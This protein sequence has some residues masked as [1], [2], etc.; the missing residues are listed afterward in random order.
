MAA[1]LP[2]G[3][4][5]ADQGEGVVKR[6]VFMTGLLRAVCAALFLAMAA[7][8]A[9]EESPAIRGVIS[10]QL[11]AFQRDDWEGAF[12][13]ASPGIRSM[14]RTPENFGRMVRGGYA[15]VWRPSD[16]EFGPLEDGPR[17]P[18]QIVYFIDSDG[19]RWVAAYEMEQVDGVWRIDGVRIRR[20]PDAAV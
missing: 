20:M 3:A 19:A 14:F 1:P 7:P 17:G 8:A 12:A 18:V 11:E 2:G 4:G 9:A 5:A 16:V 10:D 6:E 15:M 13:F